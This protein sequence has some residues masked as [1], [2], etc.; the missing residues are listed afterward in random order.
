MILNLWEYLAF[1]AN[2]MVFLLIGLNTDLTLLWENLG[3]IV[4]AVVAVVGSRAMVVYGFSW[5]ARLWRKQGYFPPS[6]RHVLFWGG[7]RGAISLALALSLPVAMPGRSELQAMA[8]GVVL[9][10]LLAQGTTIQFLLERLGLTKRSPQWV[11][12]ERRLGRLFAT[13]AGLRWLEQLHG[14]GLLPDEMWVGLKK[15]YDHDRK[16]IQQE[17]NELFREYSDLEGEMLF[18]AR[19]G[20]LQA[21]RGALWDARQR[22]LLSDPVYQELSAEIDY[23]LAALDLIYGTT[24]ELQFGGDEV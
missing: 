20:A 6:W 15:G 18:Q 1:L 13:R 9:F 21:E 10:T 5:L 12:R 2:S 22:H 3:A 11:A 24:H 7:L 17:M 14:E 4:V 23:R 16:L 8:F 19:Q